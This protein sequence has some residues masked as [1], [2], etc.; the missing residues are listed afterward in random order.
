[1]LV[2]GCTLLHP[3]HHLLAAD[4]SGADAEVG[5]VSGSLQGH[6]C[7]LTSPVCGTVRIQNLVGLGGVL[8]LSAFENTFS[9]NQSTCDHMENPQTSGT[10][11]TFQLVLIFL[12]TGATPVGLTKF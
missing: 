8:G 12:S 11:G 1:M 2:E 10:K 5:P 3:I 4:R 7:L 9:I 6:F